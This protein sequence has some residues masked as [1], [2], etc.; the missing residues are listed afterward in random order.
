[1][2]AFAAV[3]FGSWSR[4]HASVLS[5]S[6]YSISQNSSE[7]GISFAAFG[8]ST[9]GGLVQALDLGNG[10]WAHVFDRDNVLTLASRMALNVTQV[11]YILSFNRG[12]DDYSSALS[13]DRAGGSAVYVITD[14]VRA[15]HTFQS[16]IEGSE[17]YNLQAGHLDSANSDGE[18]SGNLVSIKLSK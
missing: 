14:M 6:S 5:E 2:A 12:I 7:S 18:G 1:M 16:G 10:N 17:T 11:G 15:S 4:G 8:G 3:V 13:M 9:E